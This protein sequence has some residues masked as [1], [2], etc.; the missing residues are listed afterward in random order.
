MPFSTLFASQTLAILAMI[1]MP[2]F[3]PERRIDI[4][5]DMPA[6]RRWPRSLPRAAQASGASS[7]RPPA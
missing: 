6:G 4:P 2:G 5:A 1:A 3:A 7:G